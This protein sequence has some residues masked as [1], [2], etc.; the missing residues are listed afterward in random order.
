MYNSFQ[1][2]YTVG[3]SLSLGALLLALATLLGLR[4]ARPPCSAPLRP[5][6]GKRA[7]GQAP[8]R[9]PHSKLHCTRNYIHANLFASFV[10]KASSVLVIDTLLKTRYSQKIGDDLSVSVWLSDGVS[11]QTGPPGLRASR[12]QGGR[13]PRDPSS[14]R[15]CGQAVAGCRVAA[16]FM[17]YGIVANYCWLLVEGVYLH[18]LL[19]LAAF[20]ER[21]FFA[22]YLGLGWGE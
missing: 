21:S 7:G 15:P 1:V 19:G 4:Y 6:R 11:T 13:W 5:H 18:S 10:L 12:P 2:M 16:V 14:P 20:P 9:C 3:Y 8:T 17:Q 22:L